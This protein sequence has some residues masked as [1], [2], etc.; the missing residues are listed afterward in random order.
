V[1]KLIKLFKIIYVYFYWKC[2]IFLLKYIKI[3]CC[4]WNLRVI[5]NFLNEIPQK[6]Q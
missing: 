4:Q 2:K 3:F 6:I 5:L 1:L